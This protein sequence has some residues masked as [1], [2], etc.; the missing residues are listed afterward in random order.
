MRSEKLNP[1]YKSETTASIENVS[2][3]NSISIRIVRTTNMGNRKCSL[4]NIFILDGLSLLLFSFDSLSP[5][6]NFSKNSSNSDSLFE[7]EKWRRGLRMKKQRGD[8]GDD[9]ELCHVGIYVF[10]HVPIIRYF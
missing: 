1:K 4:K 10:I 9:L 2:N 7:T 8:G 3:L 6:F 5:F